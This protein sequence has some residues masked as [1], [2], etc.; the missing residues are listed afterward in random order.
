MA[1]VRAFVSARV[2]GADGAGALVGGGDKVDID[3]RIQSF[4]IHALATVTA[5]RALQSGWP[6]ADA[7]R[8]DALMR[9]AVEERVQTADQWLGP[10]PAR[11]DLIAAAARLQT[12]KFD[13]FPR[14]ADFCS[15][16]RCPYLYALVDTRT[17][18]RHVAAADAGPPTDEQLIEVA[19]T[20]A[21]DVMSVST[22]APQASEALNAAR[23]RATACAAQ[24]MRCNTDDPNE[25]ADLVVNALKTA[26]WTSL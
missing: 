10:T 3:A 11:V 26:G 1:D 18:P 22:A 17:S 20:L 16:N 4:A 12:R 15:D 8:L 25:Q 21:A 6:A 19:A 24:L 23:W 5:R 13:P 2:A 14:C 7:A 9:A